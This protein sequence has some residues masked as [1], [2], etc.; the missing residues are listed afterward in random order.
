MKYTNKFLLFFSFVLVLP[1]PL[2]GPIAVARTSRATVRQADKSW[3]QFYA[4]FRATVNRRDKI[5]LKRMMASRFDWA[6][7][8]YVS[9]EQAL[10]NI[11]RIVGWDKFWL[12]AKNAMARRVEKCNNTASMNPHSGYC[13]YARSPR[14]MALVFER[15]SDGNWYWSA[16]PGD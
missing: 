14:A 11:G 16:F 3:Q 6:M 5:V 10:Q 13:A 15:T 12:S 7:D 1:L 4:A 2:M 8:G 9:S